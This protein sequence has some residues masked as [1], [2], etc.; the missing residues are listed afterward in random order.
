MRTWKSFHSSANVTAPQV[1]DSA[2]SS[3]LAESI[4]RT[5]VIRA[6][7][8]TRERLQ[9]RR[10]L[11]HRRATSAAYTIPNHLKN[12]RQDVC[13]GLMRPISGNF[14]ALPQKALRNL[15]T[16]LIQNMDAIAAERLQQRLNE[17]AAQREAKL[18]YRAKL[19]NDIIE[20]MHRREEN[21]Q[22]LERL[23]GITRSPPDAR[24]QD[25]LNEPSVRIKK[26]S[27]PR[28]V[29]NMVLG[30]CLDGLELVHVSH[31]DALNSLRKTVA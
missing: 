26:L 13:S 30:E 11:N 15:M 3:Y 14:E 28:A 4:R 2:N 6:R 29:K 9:R 1:S 18:A 31:P 10:E 16:P 5:F 23:S 8:A 21:T 19:R 24:L 22:A 20:D 17:E 7:S 27:E 12:V 25:H